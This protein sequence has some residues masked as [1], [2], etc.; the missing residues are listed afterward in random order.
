MNA[1]ISAL[2][3]QV[4]GLSNTAGEDLCRRHR[5]RSVQ[6]RLRWKSY[7]SLVYGLLSV[8]CLSGCGKVG[9]P[10]PPAPR[11]PLRTR[12]L[13]IFQRGP[14]LVLRWPNPNAQ[15]LESLGFNLSRIDVYRVIE[16]ASST[17]AALTEEEFATQASLIGSVD[18]ARLRSTA[19]GAEL[20]FADG[21]LTHFNRRHYYAI[22][23][24]STRG[25]SAA[26]SNIVHAVP[27]GSVAVAPKG[28]VATDQAQG[29]IALSWTAP[30]V[31]IDGST[32]ASVLGYNVYRRTA[33]Q[34]QLGLPLNGT[35]PVPSTEFL[36]R[37]FEYGSEYVYV[38]R[39]ISRSH[40]GEIIESDDSEFVSHMPRDHFAPATPE[41]LTAGS[42]NAVISLFWTANNEPDLAGYNIYRAERADAPDAEWIKLNPQIHTRI[43]FR[44][45]TTVRG[46]TY[47]YRIVAVDRAGNSSRPTPVIEQQAQ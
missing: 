34:L 27:V 29:V 1:Q 41:G 10:L 23:Y 9:D 38:V 15:T 33:N 45:E 6:H 16:S 42:A 13:A 39:A 11:L 19:A 44:D 22:R 28:L 17:E 8:L 25:Q 35:T 21:P 3:F 31:N 26:L 14:L 7:W 43:T 5:T 24:V 30:A 36:D 46:K 32:P 4:S 2:S 47:F 37:Q 12:E 20:L 18:E 40:T